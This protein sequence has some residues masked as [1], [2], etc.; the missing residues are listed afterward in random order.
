MQ[1]SYVANALQICRKIVGLLDDVGRSRRH[2]Y[3][4]ASV[5]AANISGIV[6]KISPF[7]VEVGH[8]PLVHGA[9]EV[10]DSATSWIT[11]PQLEIDLFQTYVNWP[12]VAGVG[13]ASQPPFSHVPYTS[14]G[15]D[16][17]WPAGYQDDMAWLFASTT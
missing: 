8:A 4:V 12:S 15:P 7:A 10:A 9:P 14:F 17:H 3:S 13:A 16:V 1:S 2:G 5:Y 6:A 11:Q